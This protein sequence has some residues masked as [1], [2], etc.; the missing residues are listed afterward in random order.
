MFTTLNIATSGMVAQRTRLDAISAN[1]ANMSTTRDEHG[2]LAPYQ[3]RFVVLNTDESIG[4]SSGAVGV[5]VSSIERENVEPIYK[6][7]PNHP[8][9]IQTGD[10]KGWVAYPNVD[11]NAEFVDAL[12]ATR[13]YEANVGLVEIAKGMG[14]QL[15][16]LIG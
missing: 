12:L 15:L 13:A 16:R 2:N 14:Q 7:E 1:I 6:Y 3:S 10:R 8:H 9:A 5:R 4:T 11:M